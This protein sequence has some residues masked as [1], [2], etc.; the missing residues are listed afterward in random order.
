MG[1]CEEAWS[2]YIC[3]EMFLALSPL[4]E[5]VARDPNALHRDAGR[6][7]ARRRVMDVQ[8]KQPATARR[9]VRESRVIRAS[10]VVTY[11]QA[12]SI[13]RERIGQANPMP[14]VE[15][16][17]LEEVRERVLAEDVVADRDL[18]PFHRAIRDGYAL[19][20][21]DLSAL[22]AVL[23]CVGE[24]PPGNILRGKWTPASAL[25]S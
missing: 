14:P 4:G 16:V 10:M 24:V 3:A 11:A 22:P 13:V 8:G 19:R 18:P 20:A 1:T 21:A 7:F 23:Q 15:T 25:R 5:R 2:F 6:A 17:S 9:R 12:I